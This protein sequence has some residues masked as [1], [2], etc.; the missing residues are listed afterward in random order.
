MAIFWWPSMMIWDVMPLPTNERIHESK[1]CARSIYYP[2]TYLATKSE[3]KTSIFKP[4]CIALSSNVHYSSESSLWQVSS[5][6]RLIRC[7]IQDY[8]VVSI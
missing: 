4:I 2:C 6:F 1:I 3:K 7:C 5:R 8:Q